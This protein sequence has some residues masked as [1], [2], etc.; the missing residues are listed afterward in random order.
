MDSLLV[1]RNTVVA[2]V[3]ASAALVSLPLRH[4]GTTVPVIVQARTSGEAAAAVR[5]LGG[6]VTHD[7]EVVDGVGA[8]VT[9]AQLAFLRRPA[10]GLRVSRSAVTGCKTKRR[11]R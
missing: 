11:P 5:H 6:L 4:E 2:V 9:R 7:L 10:S 8:R 1:A 3:T